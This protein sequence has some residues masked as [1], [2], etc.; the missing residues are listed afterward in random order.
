[1]KIEWDS[2]QVDSRHR[3]PKASTVHGWLAKMRGTLVGNES[4]RS[5]GMREMREARAIRAHIKEKKAQQSSSKGGV[6]S[7]FG[8]KTRKKSSRPGT[9]SR[10]GSGRIVMAG[11]GQRSHHHT[12]SHRL[13]GYVTHKKDKHPPSRGST[14]N[15]SRSSG[16][17]PTHQSTSRRGQ[18]KR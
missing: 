15:R 5:R 12:T 10:S 1:M 16:S 8:G 4:L 17:R 14:S 7:F 6:L 3:R 9:S 13:V 2:D 11:G 18:H